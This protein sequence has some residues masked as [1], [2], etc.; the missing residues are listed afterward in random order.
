MVLFIRTLFDS[1]QYN[2]YQA[3]RDQARGLQASS[4]QQKAI[5]AV[6]LMSLPKYENMQ[7]IAPGR[8]ASSAWSVNA[9]NSIMVRSTP[10]YE[11]IEMV[12]VGRNMGLRSNNIEDEV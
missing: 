9:P 1:I 6:A 5:T 4:A 3:Q 12:E 2:S 8:S 11:F 10:G 7:H